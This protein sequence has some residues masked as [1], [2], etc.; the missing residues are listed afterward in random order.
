MPT[1]YEE[2]PIRMGFFATWGT[3]PEKCGRG[4]AEER[5]VGNHLKRN[6]GP[7]GLDISAKHTSYGWYKDV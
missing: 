1:S 6:W 7:V 2:F 5:G 3:G 4:E